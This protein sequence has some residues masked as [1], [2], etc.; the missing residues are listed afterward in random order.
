MEITVGIEETPSPHDQFEGWVAKGIANLRRQNEAGEAEE[1]KRQGEAK[2][3]E[4]PVA[5]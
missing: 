1:E 3:P 2:P 4:P 5:E